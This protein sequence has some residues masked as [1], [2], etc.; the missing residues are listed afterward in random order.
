MASPERTGRGA[1]RWGLLERNDV[2]P[3]SLTQPEVYGVQGGTITEFVR[4]VKNQPNITT[5]TDASWRDA[6]ADL[7]RNSQHYARDC[8]PFGKPGQQLFV[9]E[10]WADVNTESGPAFLYADGSLKFCSDDAFPVEYERYPG[11]LFSMWWSD[12]LHAKERKCESDHHWRPIPQ[13]K[14][15]AS[16]IT[17]ELTGVTVEQI[18]GL[19]NWILSVKKVEQS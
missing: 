12:L 3:I 18:D 13:M 8:C 11:C 10:K 9:R 2:K 1:S 4:V 7:W 6:K 5:A 16:R 19:W 17:I 15:W 14:Q